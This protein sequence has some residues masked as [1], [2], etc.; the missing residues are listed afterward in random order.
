MIRFGRLGRGLA[1]AV[2]AAVM[3]VAGMAA[4]RPAAA[5]PSICEGEVAPYVLILFDTSGS[6]NWGPPCSQAELD[7]GFCAARCD[8]Y[9]CFVP[10]QADDPGSKL[11]QAKQALYE[12]L[13]N[14]TGLQFGFATL[15]QDTL[16]ARAKHWL[17]EAAGPGVNIPVRGPFPSTGSREVF[18]LLWGCDTGTGNNEIGCYAASPADFIDGW[19]LGRVQRLP[20]LGKSF[21]ESVTFYV[22]QG[23]ITYKVR[24]APVGLSTPGAPVTVA[25]TV[26]R[27]TNAACSTTTLHGQANVLFNPVSELLSW[28]D[29]SL[30]TTNPSLTYFGYTATDTDATNTC[31]GWEPNTD[32]YADP[33]NGHNLHAPTSTDPRGASFSVGDVIP[34]DWLSTHRD[35]I[36]LRLAPNLLADPLGSP[37][38]RIAPYLQDSPMAV[39]SFLRLKNSNIR[40][41]IAQGS[42]P[43][44]LSIQGFRTWWKGCSAGSCGGPAGW[45]AVA[46][47]QDP[48][49]FC[50]RQYLLVLTD[51]GETCG[52]DPC[53]ETHK[54]YTSEN[55]K[56]YVVGFGV[57][58][59]S[60]ASGLNCMASYGGTSSAYM[61][62]TRKDL[63]DTL[64]AI[65]ADMKAGI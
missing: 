17:Y 15:N 6:M 27:C 5:Q 49:W 24:Y 8:S 64:N 21:T 7:A 32:S 62:R 19:E 59:S 11:Y 35:D 50:R 22:R 29:T 12:V 30:K 3:G 31:S 47:A 26:W 18:G 4:A 61:P 37:D 60:T 13:A 48:D 40:P 53:A 34:Q 44:A 42:T 57:A 28:E 23:T 9:D 46:Q 36:L 1:S 51:G 14:T 65:F 33:F 16:Y 25:E 38:F 63:V 52:P 10:L 58:D 56:S 2:V 43:L 54:L 39:E 55:V 45:L 20:K 41:L